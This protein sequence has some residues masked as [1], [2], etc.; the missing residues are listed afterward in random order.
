MNRRIGGR[1]IVAVFEL[2]GLA[3][4]AA[5]GCASTS[6][7][8]TTGDHPPTDPTQIYIYQTPPEKYMILCVVTD[9]ITPGTTWDQGGNV[10][11][12]FDR[13]KAAA[14]AMGANGLLMAD[15]QGSTDYNVMA[16][17]HG[18]MY[19]VPMRTNPKTA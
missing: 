15:S 4:L 17:Y 18:V 6:G 16:G 8:P 13:L 14:A 7:V 5:G 1:I 9:P 10:N 2:V 11:D 19:Q 3:V 12:G